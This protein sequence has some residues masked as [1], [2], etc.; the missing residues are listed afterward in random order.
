MMCDPPQPRPALIPM[1][2]ASQPV[3]ADPV[4]ATRGERRITR[5]QESLA[6]ADQLGAHVSRESCPAFA[7]HARPLSALV[8]VWNDIVAAALSI[9]DL[10]GLKDRSNA[11]LSRVRV[12]CDKQGSFICKVI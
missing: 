10:R 8:Q 12:L 4:Q 1:D 5:R 11:I 6:M 7:C 9:A 3:P 2:M